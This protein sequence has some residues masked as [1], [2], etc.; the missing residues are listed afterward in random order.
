MPELPEVQTVVD[1]LNLKVKNRKIK[2][3]WT[4][5]FS[6]SYIGKDNIKNKK[7]FQKFKKEIIGQKILKA[8]RRAK[9]IIIHLSGGKYILIHLKMSGHLIYGDYI[10]DKKKNE[11]RSEKGYF[12]REEIKKN[13]KI[14]EMIDREPTRDPF[15][16]F[17]HF[18]L[19]FENGKQLVMSD[20]RKFGSVKL[21]DERGLKELKEKL[22]P[23]PFDLSPKEFVELVRKKGKGRAK[24]IL[25]KPEFIAGIGNIYSD[26]ILW[27]V[28]V[29]PESN[30]QNLPDE[31][32]K[33]ILRVAKK[34]LKAS[35]D[36][37]GDS[38][39]DFRN[40]EGRKGKYQAKHNAYKLEGTLCKKKDC[41]GILEKKMIGQRVGRW[42]PVHQKKIKNY[43][44]IIK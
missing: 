25:M 17:I 41:D 36:I 10:F 33:E 5:Y 32:L 7:Y 2:D 3:V 14:L 27:E 20:L 19:V 12:D 1:G 13:P 24:N 43:D 16:K 23:E 18:V 8:E 9:N 11:W 26:E 42:C 31:K 30:L 29:H 40:I 38:M 28:G 15:N 21:I 4:D 22:G 34:I 44:I 39:S 6:D 35:I 37:G